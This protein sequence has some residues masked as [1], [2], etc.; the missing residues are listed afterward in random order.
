MALSLKFMSRHAANSNVRV[1]QHKNERY[2]MK[3]IKIYLISFLTSIFCLTP[4]AQ[5]NSP[6]RILNGCTIKDGTH[7]PGVNWEGENLNYS[8]LNRANLTGA[9]LKN[10]RLFKTGLAHADLRNADLRG[11]NLNR[12]NL[13]GADLR[14][15]NIQGASMR[16]TVLNGAIWIDGRRCAGDPEAI[17][18]ISLF[19][20]TMFGGSSGQCR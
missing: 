15:A 4:L 1:S 13:V 2:F 19:S 9:N 10:S 20:A 8:K 11:A 3:F 6:P 7:C 17:S 14:G 12:A 5:E 16:S 18:G